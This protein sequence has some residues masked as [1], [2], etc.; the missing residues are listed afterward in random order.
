MI[1][2]GLKEMEKHNVTISRPQWVSEAISA[3]KAGSLQ[4]AKVIV[5]ETFKLGFD[6]SLPEDQ[7]KKA[8]KKQWKVDA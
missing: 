5:H 4:T 2:K 8:M 3:E 7:L 1:K 6:S